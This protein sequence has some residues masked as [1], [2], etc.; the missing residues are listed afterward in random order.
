MALSKATV[1]GSFILGALALG[2]GALLLF[3]GSQLFV[4]H[5][6]VVAFFEGSV[7]GLQVGAPVT[8]KGVRVGVVRHISIR[9]SPDTAVARIPVL[10]DLD[11]GRIS[12]GD[13]ELTGTRYRK[14]IDAGLRAELEQQSLITGD[15]SVDLELR[16]GTPAHLV[17]ALPGVLEIPTIPS[18]FE[19]LRA[20]LYQLQ[21]GSLIDAA[22][23]ALLA[24]Q[25]LSTH[26]DQVVDP[27]ADSARHTADTASE[28]LQTAD[29]A[30]RQVQADASATLRSIKSLS[31]DSRQQINARG[32][33]LGRALAQIDATARKA[34]T[35][36]DSVNALVAP[37]SQVRGDLESALRDLAASAS[38]LRNFSQTLERDPSALLTGATQ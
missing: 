4:R 10:M 34:D 24:I 1:V 21:L 37:R 20:S 11:R 3:G 26:L 16:P 25:K 32:A 38:S 19:R 30:I 14:L 35:L 6:R 17:G 18:G 2:I 7:A 28:T 13:G 33:D 22:Q 36:L 23:R 31:D 27:L 29:A 15:L 12:W 5:L 9:L 8:F